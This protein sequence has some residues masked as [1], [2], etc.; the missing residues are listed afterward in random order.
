MK[1]RYYI[2]G[3]VALSCTASLMAFGPAAESPLMYYEMGG[4]EPIREPVNVITLPLLSVEAEF[5][6]PHSCDLWD[7]K[8][9]DDPIDRFETLVKDHIEGTMDQLGQQI[10]INVSAHAEGLLAATIQRAMPGMYDYAQ[11]VHGQLSTEIEVA[12][13]SCERTFDR[14]ENG[15]NPLNIWKEA[16]SAEAW[17]EALGVSFNGSGGYTVAGSENILRA[18]QS[19]RTNEGATSVPWFGGNKGGDG[20]EPINVVEDTI[21]AGYALQSGSTNTAEVNTDTRTVT[22][23]NP[24]SGENTRGSRLGTLWPSSNDAVKW[25]KKVVGAVSYTHLTLPTNREV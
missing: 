2:F 14:V 24:E 18:E 15:N 16:S 22:Y 12:K 20:D 19:I 23:N 1:K 21:K 3:A 5:T 8:H 4:G 17:K 9:L 25:A 11:N 10:L 6:A 7:F 13:G